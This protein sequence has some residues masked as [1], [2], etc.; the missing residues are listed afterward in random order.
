MNVLIIGSGGREH[1]L[2]WKAAQ[3]PRL[4][5]LYI[6]PGN[7]GTS[8]VAENVPLAAGDQPALIAFARER[9]IDL[10]IVGPEA[11]LAEG[12]TDVLR[13]AGVR[14]FGPTQA[15]AQIEASK[16]FAKDFM[17]RHRIPT[18]RYQTFGDFYDAL[19]H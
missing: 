18:A 1:A 9:H 2:A 15:A 11:P 17:A 4:A 8:S 19:G 5:R 13:A 3:S 16:P 7:A 10:V 12:V 6:A 14:V